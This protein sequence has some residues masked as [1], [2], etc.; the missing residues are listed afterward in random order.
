[1]RPTLT[2]EFKGGENKDVLEDS[3]SLDGPE[4]FFEYVAPGGGC[5]GLSS[6]ADEIKVIFAPPAHPNTDNPIA[7]LGAHLELGIVILSGPLS[8]VV[9]TAEQIIDKAGRGELSESFV[10]VIGASTT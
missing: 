7:D 4:A 2:V 5:D 9:Q 6:S 3:I 1:M 8:E 10:K